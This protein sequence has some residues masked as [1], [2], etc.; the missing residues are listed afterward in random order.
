MIVEFEPE[1]MARI[2]LGEA[3]AYVGPFCGPEEGRA[4]AKYESFTV[5]HE[6]EVLAC[7]GVVPKWPGVVTMWGLFGRGFPQHYREG[8]IFAHKWLFICP[9]RRLETYCTLGHDAGERL[10]EHLGFVREG[11]M[12][13]CLPDGRD[14]WMFA[15]VYDGH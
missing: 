13:Q 2:D 7:A 11:L 6:G 12:R 1:H 14:A 4:L 9:V 10:L 3:Q 15:R 8:Y 5:L